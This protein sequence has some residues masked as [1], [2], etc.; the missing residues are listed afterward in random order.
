MIEIDATSA[1]GGVI[2]VA[3]QSFRVCIQAY[4]FAQIAQ[5][6]GPDAD[7]I[8]AKLQVEEYRLME[9]ARKAKLD[10]ETYPDSRLNWSL[11]RDLLQQQEALLTSSRRVKEKYNLNVGV[12]SGKG[13]K[14]PPASGDGSS[15]RKLLSKLKPHVYLQSARIIQAS[16]GPLKRLQWATLGKSQAATILNGLAEI[17]TSL[18]GL[19][20]SVDQ[21][22]V[23]SALT[24][25]LREII[26]HSTDNSQLETVKQLLDGN[27][28]HDADTVTSAA[29]L[30]QIRLLLGVDRRSDE[31]KSGPN[32][33]MQGVNRKVIK[34]RYSLLVQERPSSDCRGREIAQYKSKLVL[35]EWKVV[36]RDHKRLL[37]SRVS[38]LVLLLS[39]APAISYH[40]LPCMG[41]IVHDRLERYAI[42]FELPPFSRSVTPLYSSLSGPVD[43]SIN[44]IAVKNLLNALMLSGKPSLDKR[45]HIA[46]SLAET[47]LQLHTSG[48][49]HKGIR[50]EN[51]LFVIPKEDDW[52]TFPSKQPFLIGYEYTRADGAEEMTE[53]PYSSAKIDI[54]R[55]PQARGQTREL[56]RKAFDLYGLG[57]IF[58]ELA[59]WDRLD[60]ILMRYASLLLDQKSFAS[61]P[62][63]PKIN[64]TN[65]EE[66]MKIDDDG[67]LGLMQDVAFHMGDTFLQVVQLC[68]NVG[69]MSDDEAS[70]EVQERI[71]EQLR[72]C[73]Y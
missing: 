2:A 36:P 21:D 14:E 67:S 22:F 29:S 45:V 40:S 30:K 8:R 6:L 64:P 42:V 27:S 7:N 38:G 57:C 49:L 55:H 72:Q 44:S 9:W 47:L 60:N 31:K 10:H 24:V 66:L 32:T 26:S 18:E 53:D 16:N 13:G 63:L 17:N 28:V 54:Y 3:V 25:L 23:K 33:Q 11:I 46:L 58:L 34:M 73:K 35:V 4:E 48:W 62:T 65:L 68:F 39:N 59:L 52:T 20:D 37:E 51:V 1:I 41:Y 56:F 15:L 71:V 12:E 43:N 5:H 69:D 61:Q 70:L 50:S 19:L